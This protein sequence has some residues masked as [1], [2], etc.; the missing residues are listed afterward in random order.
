MRGA[1][2]ASVIQGVAGMVRGKLRAN[3]RVGRVPG[4][5]RLVRSPGAV[6]SPLRTGR[7]ADLRG[8]APFGGRSA[9]LA[10]IAH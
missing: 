6:S 3:R 4:V 7:P 9:R 8:E 2:R 10:A 5:G 1:R